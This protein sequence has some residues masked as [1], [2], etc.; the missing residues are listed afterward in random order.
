MLGLDIHNLFTSFG[1]SI[2]TNEI[3]EQTETKK[4]LGADQGGQ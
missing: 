4:H 3:K 2:E 1:R